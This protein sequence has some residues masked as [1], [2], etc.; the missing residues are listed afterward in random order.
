MKNYVT[1]L[2]VLFFFSKNAQT[3]NTDN[4]HRLTSITSN[5]VT[6]TYIYD[7]VGNRITYNV[8]LKGVAIAPKAFLQGAYDGIVV[9]RDDLR[10]KG[11]IPIIEPYSNM[12]GFN[13]L[14][15]GGE[16]VHPVILQQTGID[17]IVD[18]VFLE[19]RDSSNV[20]SVVATISALIQKDGDIVSASD[21]KSVIRF[22]LMNAGSYYIVI[23][24]RNH[25]TIRSAQPIALSSV[26]TIVDFTDANTP[27]ANPADR[28]DLGGGLMAMWGGNAKA[29][30]N[31]IRNTPRLFP[32]PPLESDFT[33]LL[34]TSLGGNPDAT[35]TGYH[36]S[37][38]NMD[39]VV[40]AKPVL[41]PPPGTPS[42]ATFIL[43]NALDG[44]FNKTRTT[45]D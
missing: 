44:D 32:P 14:N 36:T 41:F 39:G 28:V 16:R 43:D 29:D 22:P 31:Y 45:T 40:R 33:H 8:S 15:G 26:A 19:L 5:E 7:A 42:D 12:L 38:V 1:I 3:I 34:N 20:D 13:P 2:C 25:L 11:Y 23:R 9:M 6:T 17:A 35:I 37:D 21:G 18:W 30:D 24:H 4:L 10:N 27:V